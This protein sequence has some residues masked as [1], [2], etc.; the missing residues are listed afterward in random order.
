MNNAFT[1]ELLNRIVDNQADYAQP[2]LLVG[3]RVHLF[4]SFVDVM[5]GA[6]ILLGEG[7]IVGTGPG[8]VTA[9]GDDNA[10]VIDCAGMVIVPMVVDVRAALSLNSD[11]SSDV[12]TL[13][14]GNTGSF[15][16]VD[17]ELAGDGASAVASVI[18]RPESVAAIFIDGKVVLW[19]G[20]RTANA[21]APLDKS[22]VGEVSPSTSPYV[23]MWIDETDFLHQELTADGRYDETRGGR[24][25]A[26][27]GAYWIDGDRIDYLD[28]LGFWAFG[29]F[30]DGVLHHGPYILNRGR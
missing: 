8:I 28:D 16:V 12:G 19:N 18:G 13:W 14:P 21:P 17:A 7:F 24:P 15:A 29:E 26:F 9:A 2:L 25:H 5:E 6:D 27:Q 10:L 3:A 30:V 20:E 23:G 11:R 22:H 4:D 1:P